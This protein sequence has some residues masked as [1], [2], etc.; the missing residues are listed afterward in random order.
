MTPS[1]YGEVVEVQAILGAGS[2]PGVDMALGTTAIFAHI[3]LDLT[4]ANGGLVRIDDLV[5]ED[6]TSAFLRDMI[7]LVDV[8]DYG[9]KGDGLTN[10]LAAFQA[11]D[12]AAG[13]R[14]VL[15]SAGTR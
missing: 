9:A 12:L 2:K 13:G 14:T 8:R 6:I 5:V 7:D 15:V 10:D 4:G 1:A 11:A 3:G